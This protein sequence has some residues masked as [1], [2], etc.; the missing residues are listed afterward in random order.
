MW[1]RSIAYLT[2]SLSVVVAALLVYPAVLS[3]QDSNPESVTEVPA[4]IPDTVQSADPPKPEDAPG[5]PKIGPKLS[6]TWGTQ[7]DDLFTGAFCGLVTIAYLKYHSMDFEQNANY[8]CD[9]EA[10]GDA[11]FNWCNLLTGGLKVKQ[12]NWKRDL[13]NGECEAHGDY[14]KDYL[15]ACKSGKI[16]LWHGFVGLPELD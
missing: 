7:H 10:V 5:T 16:V 14:L 8:T 9:C 6:W 4:E 13:W 2:C 11:I 1:V 3:A 15:H 12:C